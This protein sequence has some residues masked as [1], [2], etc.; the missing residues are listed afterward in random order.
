MK[1]ILLIIAG[2]IVVL[3]GITF[4]FTITQV[5]QER[6]SLSADLEYRTKLLADSLKESIEPS[7]SVG[8]IE[9]LQSIVIKF[10]DRERLAGLAV[11]KADGGI[12]ASSGEL[13]SIIQ[14]DLPL[15]AQAMDFNASQG[16]FLQSDGNNFY[17]FASPLREGG[18][19]VG[20]LLVIQN[21][22]YINSTTAHILWNNLARLAVQ[23]L[24]FSAVVLLIVRWIVVKPLSRLAESV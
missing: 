24:F 12:I 9:S 22:N 14:R 1:H 8:S 2:G 16:E 21:A 23:T 20:S 4:A 5:A 11:M 13:P 15:V 18:V 7:Y 17:V 19:A 10:S 6:A 3:S